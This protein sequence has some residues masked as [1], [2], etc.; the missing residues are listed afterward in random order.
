[1]FS[2]INKQKPLGGRLLRNGEFELPV[3]IPWG[4][5]PLWMEPRL[6]GAVRSLL[7]SVACPVGEGLRWEGR[8]LRVN[9]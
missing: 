4:F 1:M 2:T 7:F 9:A 5:A 6:G 8:E 3:L